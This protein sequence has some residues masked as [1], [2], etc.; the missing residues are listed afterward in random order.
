VTHTRSGLTRCVIVATLAAQAASMASL[1]ATVVVPPTFAQ[2]VDGAREI[3]V[4]EV[5]SRQSRW[6]TTSDGPAIVTLR[7][8]EK[9]VVAG[10]RLRV[11]HASDL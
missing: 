5:V 4:G 10:W 1:R 7:R 6:V 11:S 8:V 2:L 3:F 9:K